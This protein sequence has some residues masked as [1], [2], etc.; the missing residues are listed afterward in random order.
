[1]LQTLCLVLETAENRH[2]A[3]FMQFSV[4]RDRLTLNRML[5]MVNTLIMHKAECRDQEDHNL[6]PA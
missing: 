6:R 3:A 4:S 2:D 1:V 5:E